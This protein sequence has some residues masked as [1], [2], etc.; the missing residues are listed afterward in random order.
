MTNIAETQITNQ[1]KVTKLQIKAERDER[2]AKHKLAIASR[3]R[4]LQ[5]KTFI[6]APQTPLN[7]LA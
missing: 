4:T 1:I 6:V 7:I 2:V 5:T 3:S